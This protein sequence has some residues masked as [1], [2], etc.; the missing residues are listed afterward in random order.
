MEISPEA[1]TVANLYLSRELDADAVAQELSL[2]AHTI[3]AQL[4]KP[5]IKQYIQDTLGEIGYNNRQKL[6]SVMDDLIDR[7][8]EEMQELELTS[9][10]DILDLVA[11]KHK[12]RMDELKLENEIEKAKAGAKQVNIQNN[13]SS[14][15]ERLVKNV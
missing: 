12:M 4:R 1:L 2:P 3:H 8:L 10:K 7:K 5:E 11:Q 6:A 13:Y 15:M 14:L 9:S